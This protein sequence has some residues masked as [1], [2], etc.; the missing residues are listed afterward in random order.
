M[1]Y[2]ISNK[3]KNIKIIKENN[4]FSNIEELYNQLNECGWDSM[5]VFLKRTM[6]F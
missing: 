3:S 6:E 2:Y 4:I 1:G 5:T